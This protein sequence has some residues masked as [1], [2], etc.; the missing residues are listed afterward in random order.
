MYNMKLALFL[1]FISVFSFALIFFFEDKPYLFS[2]EQKQISIQTTVDPSLEQSQPSYLIMNFSTM[3]ELN[4][5]APESE[6]QSEIKPKVVNELQDMISKLSR[7]NTQTKLGW[8]TLNEYMNIP[9][10]TPSTTSAYVVKIKRI[11]EISEE[12]ELPV[13]IPLNGF[14][15][16]DEQPELYNWWDNDGTKT[17]ASFF[18]RQDN[19]EEFKQRFIAG[20][21]PNNRKNVDWK[22]WSEPMTWNYRNW[23]SGE[24]I[25]APPPNIARGS[26][27]RKVLEARYSAIMDQMRFS[28]S[29]LEQKNKQ[30]LFLGFS[31]G[32][33][34]SLNASTTPKD[35]FEPYG[36]R[37]LLDSGLNSNSNQQ[38]IQNMRTEVLHEYIESLAR[39]SAR[40]GFDSNYIH[41]HVWGEEDPKSKKYAPYA[42]AACSPYVIPSVSI[43]GNEKNP[44]SSK[45]WSSALQTCNT[46]N[47][48][49]VETSISADTATQELS[50]LFSSKTPPRI[51]VLYNWSEH[52]D[53][54]Q[55]QAI[56]NYVQKNHIEKCQPPILISRNDF[57][58]HNPD[59]L[60]ITL[61]PSATSTATLTISKG[62]STN[63]PIQ[64][65]PLAQTTTVSL[66]QGMYSWYITAPTCDNT[67]TSWS[68]PRLIT[69][70]L[71]FSNQRN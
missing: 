54:S 42:Q 65:Y 41:A 18:A 10:D 46:P 33:E 70:P 11:F 6:W 13:F 59:S 5:N 16:W 14:Q 69:V 28:L 8:S 45:Q 39:I 2:T 43:Y 60:F 20:Y 9:A 53:P 31:I 40:K 63:A 21:D 4:W 37:A 49:I 67:R 1:I 44:M 29:E 71:T 34:L 35:E 15:W 23:G 26:A 57:L 19:P 12:L 58:T 3:N 7:G 62:F 36:Y 52:Q 24:F 56:A 61:P 38:S 32:T 22:S 68:Q 25:L 27:Y 17:P 64:T 30:H 55:Q 48:S 50:N 47:W 66:P 51:I